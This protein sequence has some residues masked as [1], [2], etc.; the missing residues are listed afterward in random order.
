MSDLHEP[1]STDPTSGPITPGSR[2][3][4]RQPAFLNFAWWNLHNFAHYDADRSGDQRWP[5]SDAHYEAKRER[6]LAAFREL[7]EDRFPDLLAV[8]EI[9]REAARDLAARLPAGFDLA[10]SPG[11]QREDRFQVAVFY[12]TS[13]GFSSEPP[14]IPA[15][16]ADVAE[17]TRPMVPVHF[18]LQGHVIR[19]VA[20]HLTAFDTDTSRLARERLAEVLRAD[21]Y[22]FLEPEIPPSTTR[23]VVVL[24]DLNEEPM[25]AVFEHRLI[26][27]RDRR[28]TLTRHWGDAQIRRVRLYNAAWRYLGEQ[29]AHATPGPPAIGPAG[30][31]FREPHDWR[32]FDHVLVSSSLLGASP[33]Y[34]DEARTGVVLT[35]IMQDERG[36]PRPFEPGSPRGVSDHLP[37]VG[38][39][40]L[41]E[42]SP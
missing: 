10:M 7:F 14:L 33:P 38:R 6:I 9:T 30:T 13:V 1:T 12:R 32:T 28:S 4:T 17:G 36:L 2:S 42:T 15:E 23:H 18:T 19:F 8:C 29:I 20:C 37:L 11:F 41:P 35:P 26:G 21:I 34:F 5:K 25:S 22:D 39:L 24:G 40:V 27:R 16:L 3:V 31:C